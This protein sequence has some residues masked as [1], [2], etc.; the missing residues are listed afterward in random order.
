M[1]IIKRFIFSLINAFVFLAGLL[2]GKSKKYIL[3]GGWSGKAF[4]DN[5][6]HLFLYLNKHNPGYKKIIFYTRDRK[7]F[8]DLTKRGFSCVYGH[9]IKAI[10][11]HLKCR[12]HVCDHIPSEDLLG[13]L[14]SGAKKIYLSHGFG[15]KLVG[16]EQTP[17]SYQKPTWINVIGTRGCWLNAS[18]SVTSEL[19]RDE[20]IKCYNTTDKHIFYSSQIRDF[21]LI[22]TPKKSHNTFNIFYLPTFRDDGTP[23]PLLTTDMSSLNSLFKKNNIL[24]YAKPHRNEASRWPKAV[25]SNIQILDSDVDL[26]DL[27]LDFDLV[28]SDYSSGI[29]DYLLLGK[30]T[31]NYPFDLK[32]YLEKDRHLMK[33]YPETCPM[34]MIDYPDDLLKKILSIKE[35]PIA[36]K[37]KYS[38]QYLKIK[39]ELFGGNDQLCFDDLL[40]AIKP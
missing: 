12:Y 37:K 14:S 19:I 9:S 10:F 26:Y 25:Y 18:Y 2:V 1:K 20:I 24:F 5:S 22:N 21:S 32:H 27:P 4:A 38:T 33:E 15:Y 3:I 16:N 28:I 17:G 13:I 40:A 11:Y 34:A 29:Y 31:L 23:N 36:Y 30:L 6:K 35:D 39:K 7:V 8:S